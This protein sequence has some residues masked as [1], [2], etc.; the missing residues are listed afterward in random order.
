MLVMHAC[1]G[2]PGLV[3]RG[4]STTKGYQGWRTVWHGRRHA[5]S[6][7]SSLFHRHC[8]KLLGPAWLPVTQLEASVAVPATLTST[9]SLPPFPPSRSLRYVTRKDPGTNVVYLSR[10]YYDADK[11]RN[12]F[13]CTSFNWIGGAPPA[14]GAALQCKVRH[15]PH[16]YPCVLQVGLEA[17]RGWERECGAMMRVALA[18]TVGACLCRQPP[19]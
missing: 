14:E 15:G 7:A 12:A 19:L 13:S 1:L 10:Q 3:T 4:K 17:V 16:L 6:P 11:V 5:V 18:L 8:V 9:S 2:L